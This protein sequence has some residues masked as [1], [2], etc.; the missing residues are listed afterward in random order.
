VHGLKSKSGQHC[1][2]QLGEVKAWDESA[3]RCTVGLE[4]G[5]QISL[6][7]GNLELCE[8]AAPPASASSAS[9]SFPAPL[10]PPGDNL[11][12]AQIL[13]ATAASAAEK[14]TELAELRV[15]LQQA[16]RQAE[17]Q[18]AAVRQLAEE[19][20]A[21]KADAKAAKAE[22]EASKAEAK[23]HDEWVEADHQGWKAK[24]EHFEAEAKKH[25][26]WA[27]ADQEGWKARGAAGTD[28]ADSNFLKHAPDGTKP[29]R[30]RA[31]QL[32]ESDRVLFTVRRIVEAFC[33]GLYP[34]DAATKRL[35]VAEGR[36][37]L[38]RL[39][40]EWVT[41]DNA[42]VAAERVWS[43]QQTLALQGTEHATGGE[44]GG[45]VQREFCWV[46]S[47]AIRDDRASVARPCA[48]LAH[49]LKTNLVGARQ[50]IYPRGGETWRGGGFNMEHQGFFTVGKKYRVPGFLAT[51]LR[52]A[53]TNGFMDRA[54]AQGFD[55]VQWRIEFDVRGDPRGDNKSEYRV[56]HVNELRA[57]HCP[58]EDEFLFQA[59]SVFTVT[60]V[61]WSHVRPATARHPHRITL[62][63]SY[64]NASESC[65]LPLAPWF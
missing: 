32:W 62:R 13:S 42:D 17:Q 35:Q 51:S 24:A 8:P 34:G 50:G 64:D 6:K 57:T 1:N 22:A 48:I 12:H 28:F 18:V 49:A 54:Q 33:E 40:G 29:G 44:D 45:R 37:F 27:E 21:A 30:A 25:D 2:G 19:V 7:P 39:R 63:P 41:G 65:R 26:E 5:R 61:Q 23:K 9:S 36:S 15:Q 56:K 58:G 10:E 60:E 59:Y 46:F 47:Q 3:G 11:E 43:S 38:G 4:D 14:A 16:A 55:V 52:K 53:V 31:V 20:A